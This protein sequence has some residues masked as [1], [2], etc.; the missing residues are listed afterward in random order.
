MKVQVSVTKSF[1]FSYNAEFTYNYT[2]IRSQI[3]DL[4]YSVQPICIFP[5]SSLT[6][7]SPSVSL[8]SFATM[9]LCS[10]TLIH[11]L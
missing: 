7:S 9:A 2:T 10:P 3:P 11:N 4:P 1:S 8:L 5:S 6:L